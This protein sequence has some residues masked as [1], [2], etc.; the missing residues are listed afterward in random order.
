MTSWNSFRL[1]GPVRPQPL[2]RTPPIGA[3]I[4]SFTVGELTLTMPP[5]SSA[6]VRT[7]CSV[8]GQDRR[9][10]AVQRAV[11]R[12]DRLLGGVDGLHDD[13]GTKGLL[14]G[15]GHVERHIAQDGRLIDLALEEA[16]GMEVRALGDSL[17]H[18]VVA[19]A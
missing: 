13:D 3:C 7:P 12:F 18:A 14:V 11:G 5:G 15:D 10:E 8:A 1:S 19:P 17:L 4:S 16:A 6:P 2:S 9:S